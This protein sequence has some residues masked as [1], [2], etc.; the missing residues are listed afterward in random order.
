[1]SG[2]D[3]QQVTHAYELMRGHSAVAAELERDL[4]DALH[5]GACAEFSLD[6]QP[7]TSSRTGCVVGVEALLRWHSVRRGFVSPTVFIPA[8]ERSGLIHEL[9]RWVLESACRQI[10]AWDLRGLSFPYVAVNVS[11][12]QIRAPGFVR[13]VDE[14]IASRQIDGSRLVLE[15]T[16]GLRIQ[17]TGY[18]KALFDA[19]RGRGIGMALDDFGTGYSSLAYVQTLPLTKLKIDRSFVTN[20]PSSRKDAAIVGALVN[21]ARTLNI[22]LVAEGVET[23]AQRT[24]LTEM[25]CDQI[26]GWL[27]SKALPPDELA[28][29]FASRALRMHSPAAGR[30]QSMRSRH[31]RLCT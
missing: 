1:M 14:A 6:Y 11:P 20:L 21:L 19:L 9:G 12:E 22:E 26:Q 29:C 2:Y 16:E 3:N 13:E 27:V 8:A 15:I 18:T 17:D 7:I 4:E 24:L 5:G 30:T 31:A 25:G 28:L 23:E 10:A